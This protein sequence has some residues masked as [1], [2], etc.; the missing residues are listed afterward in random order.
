MTGY[1]T[2]LTD[3]ALTIGDVVGNVGPDGEPNRVVRDPRGTAP[4][5]RVAKVAARGEVRPHSGIWDPGDEALEVEGG[6]ELEAEDGWRVA[7]IEPLHT[8][9]GPQ[10]ELILAAVVDQAIPAFEDEAESWQAAAAA[11]HAEADRLHT[12]PGTHALQDAQYAAGMALAEVG[13]DS[14]WWESATG[15]VWGSELLALAARDLLGTVE[16]WDQDAYDLLTR[17]WRRAFPGP[18]HPQDTEPIAA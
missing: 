7:A 18:L 2:L 15:C 10:G 14:Y 17:A 11:Y 16:G 1:Y 4:R 9:L 3:D 13:A 12:M 5:V 6:I 8:I